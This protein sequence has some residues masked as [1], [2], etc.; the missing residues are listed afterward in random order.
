MNPSSGNT[1]AEWVK[2]QN[3]S[4]RETETARLVAASPHDEVA[5]SPD[6]ENVKAAKW[7][8]ASSLAVQA[9]MDSCGLESEL[10]AIERVPAGGRGKAAQFIPIRFV[11]TNK[12]GKDDK[13]L[14]AFDACRPFGSTE[15]RNQP[16]QDHPRRRP[17]HAEGED[18]GLD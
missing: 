17:R 6:M 4:Y 5:L 13:L 14:L 12:L 2:A 7:R 16:R 18:L 15:A 10:H 9:E 1:Y 3:A 11:F 8:L